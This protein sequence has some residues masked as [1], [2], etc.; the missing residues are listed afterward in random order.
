MW[1]ALPLIGFLLP[2]PMWNL[3]EKD[4]VVLLARKPPTVE[5]FSFTTFALFM[6][7]R[8]LTFSSL[9]DSVN[10]HNIKHTDEGESK[11]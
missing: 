10:S 4:A 11:A 5:Y 2:S 1:S 8:G 3:G 9:G 7:G 6:P